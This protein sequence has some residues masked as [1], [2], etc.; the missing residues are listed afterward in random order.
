ML[1]NMFIDDF[2]LVSTHIWNA[3]DF[4]KFV[5]RIWNRKDLKLGVECLAVVTNETLFYRLGEQVC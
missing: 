3:S 2:L 1:F 4:C 5:F